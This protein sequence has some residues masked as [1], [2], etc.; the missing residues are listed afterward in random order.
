VSRRIILN[1]HGLGE[2]PAWIEAAERPYWAPIALFEDLVARTASRPDIEYTFDDGNRSDLDV[3]VPILRRHGRTA[4]FYI[5]TGRLEHRAYLAADDVRALV[6][7]GMSVGLHGRD[8][9][10]WRR[11]DDRQMAAETIEARD[12]LAGIV[13]RPVTAV[14]IP[15]GAYNRRVLRSL[16]ALGYETILTTDGGASD[17]TQRVRNRTS[18]R[19]DMGPAELEAILAGR[20]SLAEG[21]RRTA[22]TFLRRH[23]V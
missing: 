10:D 4:G 6:D 7:Q 12:R 16:T 11:L 3:A 2:P 23:V 17:S 20:S 21:L 8:H 13:G 1:F 5:L 9:L 15:F 14:S 19:S 18:I 22:S